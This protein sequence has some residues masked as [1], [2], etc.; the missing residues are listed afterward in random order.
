MGDWAHASYMHCSGALQ[1]LVCPF[2][3]RL[4]LCRFEVHWHD[5]N[6][7]ILLYLQT[8]IH[9]SSSLVSLRPSLV[10][11]THL[12][13]GREAWAAPPV[14]TSSRLKEQEMSSYE[15]RERGVDEMPEL[16]RR[17]KWTRNAKNTPANT[18]PCFRRRRSFEG[19]H[20]G[21]P[22]VSV[23]NKLLHKDKGSFC[24]DRT[25]TTTWLRL[26]MGCFLLISMKP[27]CVGGCFA[28]QHELTNRRVQNLQPRLHQ[29][30]TRRLEEGPA[31]H[32]CWLR[33]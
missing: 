19:F 31:V 17:C 22:F 21:G 18:L 7:R 33:D 27:D 14:P 16:R 3:S 13:R 5:L 23:L 26:W 32:C 1:G 11:M 24:E 9:R 20:V 28:R 29:K 30:R 2:L 15:L 8:K 4:V 10:Y 6:H 12:K 25:S